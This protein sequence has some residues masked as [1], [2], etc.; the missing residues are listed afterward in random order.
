MMMMI[1]EYSVECELQEKPKYSEDTCPS[2]TLSS[3]N[4]TLPDLGSNWGGG[5]KPDTNR[6][7]Y[8]KA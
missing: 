2:A 1:V 8:G 4:P 5:G 3:T 7:S 6:L